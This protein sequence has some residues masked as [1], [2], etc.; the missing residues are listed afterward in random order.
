MC[1]IIYTINQMELN[2]KMKQLK[3]DFALLTII[4]LI[5]SYIDKWFEMFDFS[6]E[7]WKTIIIVC[8]TLFLVIAVLEKVQLIIDRR[9]TER[10]C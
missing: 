5:A 9:N 10:T 3:I 7:T 2:A 1:V 6:L 4:T 8:F